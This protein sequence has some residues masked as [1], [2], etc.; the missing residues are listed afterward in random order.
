MTTK[1]EIVRVATPLRRL[2]FWTGPVVLV[3]LSFT[4]CVTGRARST[5]QNAET[6]PI[7]FVTRQAVHRARPQFRTSN[8]ETTLQKKRAALQQLVL[9]SRPQRGKQ[10]AAYMANLLIRTANNE[11]FPVEPVAVTALIESD[12]DMSSGPCVGVMQINPATYEENHR[13][14]GLN[15]RKLQDN[16]RL[17]TRELRMHYMHFAEL[18]SRHMTTDR[19]RLSYMWGR[20][21]GCGIHGSYVRKALRIYTTL[22]RHEG[23][24]V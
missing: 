15:P 23:L 3:A 1:T 12:F 19:A 22:R 4:L 2:I 17:G 8:A 13:G 10:F 16:V 24:A 18:P 5:A 9:A 14:S 6:L 7:K 11:K 20:Y 21:N